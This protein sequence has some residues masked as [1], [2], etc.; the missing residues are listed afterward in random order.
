MAEYR[1]LTIRIGAD[2]GSFTASLKAATSAIAAAEKSAR[3][4]K[5]SLVLDPG[6]NKVGQMYLGELQS[7]LVAATSKVHTLKDAMADLGS[8]GSKGEFSFGKTIAQLAQDT[9]DAVLASRRAKEAYAQVTDQL[10]T[11]YTKLSDFEKGLK[12]LDPEYKPIKINA[13]NSSMEVITSVYDKM[14]KMGDITRE[15]ADLQISHIRRLKDNFSQLSDA[16]DDARLVEQLHNDEVA[17]ANLEAKIKALAEE[18]ADAARSDLSRSLEDLARVVERV[19]SNVDQAKGRL[20]NADLELRFDATSA[21]AMEGKMDA[22]A[23]LQDV[24]RVKLDAVNEELA[25]LESEGVDKLAAS[26]ATLAKDTEAARAAYVDAEQEVTRLRSELDRALE[27]QASLKAEASTNIEGYAQ[28]TTEVARLR[29]ELKE[30]KATMADAEATYTRFKDANTFAEL[31]NDAQSLRNEIRGVITEMAEMTRSDLSISLDGAREQL[32]SISTDAKAARDRFE[33]L[34]KVAKIDPS[35]VE[36]LAARSKALAEA[37]DLASQKAQILRDILIT[38]QSAGLEEVIRESGSL[39]QAAI[40]AEREYKRAADSVEDLGDQLAKAV[41]KKKEFEAAGD[42]S[43]EEY[44]K[45]SGDVERLTTSLNEAA[46]AAMSAKTNLETIRDAM[47]LQSAKSDMTGAFTEMSELSARAD[48]IA[49]AE[50]RI[51]ESVQ[52]IHGIANALPPSIAPSAEGIDVAV[53]GFKTLSDSADVAMARFKAADEALKLNPTNLD[54][55]RERSQAA[56]EA[57]ESLREKAKAAKDLLDRYRADGI[58]KIV[59]ST[60]NLTQASAKADSNLDK[61]RKR[62]QELE[63]ALSDAETE[64]G[65]IEKGAGRGSEA[66]REASQSVEQIRSQLGSARRECDD[67]ERAAEDLK[68]ALD[69]RNVETGLREIPGEIEKIK[70]GGKEA[71]DSMATAFYQALQ[72]VGQFAKQALQEVIDASY[73]FEDAFTN[74]RKTVDAT[75]SQFQQLKDDAVA[76]SLE[77]PVS[78][79]QILNVEALGGQLGFAVEELEDFQRVANGLDIS[80]DMDWNQAATNMAQFFNIMDTEHE[81]VG[82]YGSAI[83]DLGNNFATTESAISDMAMRIAGAGKTLGLS[84]ADV[85]GISTALASMGLTAEAGGSSVS[86][87]MVKI[88]KAVAQGTDGVKQLADQAGMSVEDLISYVKSLDDDALKDFAKKFEMSGDDLKKATVGMSEQLELW[89]ETAGYK[90]ADEFAK[91]WRE[92]PVKALQDVFS[93]MTEENLKDGTN[94]SLLLDELGIKTIRQSDVSRRLAGN[95]DLLTQAVNAAND[96][97]EKNT[98]LD[99]EVERRAESLSGRM[100][101]LNNAVDV[102]KTEVGEG[103][104]PLVERA[105]TVVS[106]FAKALDRVPDSVKTTGIALTGIVAILGTAGAALLAVRVGVK[107]FAAEFATSAIATKLASAV[108]GATGAGTAV[109]ILG[110][111]L[112]LLAGPALVLGTVVAAIAAVAYQSYKAKK[113]SENFEKALG[114]LKSTSDEVAGSIEVGSSSISHFDTSAK[115]VMSVKELTEDIE[116]F[117]R[118][119]REIADPVKESNSMLG[120]YKN[121]IDQLAGKGRASADDMAL[122]EWAVDGLN[123]ALG[124]NFTAQDILLDKYKD[125][126]SE[127]DNLMGYIDRLIEKR[128]LQA[129]LEAS[130]SIYTEALKEQMELEA[131]EEAAAERYKTNL[132]QAREIYEGIDKNFFADRGINT[133]SEIEQWL[134]DNNN[135]VGQAREEW[136][137]AKAAADGATEALDKYAQKMTDVQ[138]KSTAYDFISDAFQSEDF[139]WGAALDEAKIGVT[140]FLDALQDAGLGMEDLQRIYGDT[141]VYFAEMV[142]ESGGD[143]NKLIGIIQDYSAQHPKVEVE[144]ETSE[145][146]QRMDALMDEQA[147]MYDEPV[148]IVVT[149]EDE[150]TSTIQT[151]LEGLNAMPKEVTAAIKGDISD[152]SKKTNDANSKIKGV[153]Q[154]SSTKL[155]ADPSGVYSAVTDAQTSINSLV[156]KTVDVT[157]RLIGAENITSLIDRLSRSYTLRYSVQQQANPI[158]NSGIG[159]IPGVGNGFAQSS[160]VSVFPRLGGNG[161]VVLDGGPSSGDGRGNTILNV[162]LNYKAGDDANKVARDIG[163][164]L[165]RQMRAR[166]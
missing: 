147:A 16:Y 148:S 32:E 128:Q 27:V 22:L 35:N 26:S 90:S 13:D 85:L 138:E 139:G 72:Q 53:E 9:D 70:H 29:G 43:S 161:R 93:G 108:T 104:S 150:A 46:G 54:L 156:G 162:N 100:D 129:E 62:V 87:I 78:A 44:A 149:A 8:T 58:D 158:A 124:T 103:L 50:D 18:M 144:V 91:A 163:R 111:K 31:T 28:A 95:A 99:V 7:Q 73:Q 121:V 105:I 49:A 120:E 94:L 142:E 19:S 74:V 5:R 45:A 20:Q 11:Y 24:L 14:V 152:L 61:A 116:E 133:D 2:T 146:Q 134:I 117:N 55:V 33:A 130:Q 81:N 59:S 57:M 77:S 17:A 6:N 137:A 115:D 83:V 39:T 71:A 80:T 113:E 155:N 30:A 47:D 15:E 109:G 98:A 89:A 118:T 157:A 63:S 84:E 135:Y 164:A 132:K 151:T 40:D 125:E 79:S 101:T 154:D 131:N 21:D 4:L 159:N 160:A 68:R 66:F 86:Q 56:N 37:Q 119:V 69:Y 122:L 102:V 114:G 166:R 96:A 112:A 38:L 88:E 141:S 140:D 123:D 106:G 64:L 10:A 145:A 23:N 65:K 127:I 82:R 165:E 110:T 136:D 92:T 153:K 143:L 25:R 51:R 52:R 60:K 42:T 107:K 67:A 34:D 12:A 1:G 126:E 36:V 3:S 41:A 75:D 97:W 76:A 48:E